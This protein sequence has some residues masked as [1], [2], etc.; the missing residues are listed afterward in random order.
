MDRWRCLHHQERCLQHQGRCLQ[1][2]ERAPIKH[3]MFTV[4]LSLFIC[5]SALRIV[6]AAPPGA[7]AQAAAPLAL[8]DGQPGPGAALDGTAGGAPEQGAALP[9]AAEAPPTV[10][11]AAAVG[12]KGG[13]RAMEAVSR[14]QNR[15][16]RIGR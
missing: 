15:W 4:S 3:Y 1:Q 12:S 14:T 13:L 5:C 6:V 2:R 7:P 11:S 9:A 16:G 10:A 8:A